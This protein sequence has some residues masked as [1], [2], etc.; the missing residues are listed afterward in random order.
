MKYL[1]SIILAMIAA[2]FPLISSLLPSSPPDSEVESEFYDDELLNICSQAKDKD[3]V[4][5]YNPGGMGSKPMGEDTQWKGVVEGIES[6]LGEMGYTC[7]IVEHIRTDATWLGYMKE[8]KDCVSLFSVKSREL[9]AKVKFLVE[10]VKDIK[11]IITGASMGAVFCSEVMGL[12]KADLRAYSIEAGMPF[13]HR[14]S[15]SARTLSIND[16]GVTPDALSSGSIRAIARS[17]F[18]APFRWLGSRL[19]GEH[20][21]L[22]GCAN[23]PGH[24]YYWD[25]PGVQSQIR[26]FLE[27]NFG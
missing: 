17:C 14:D 6:A 3:F 4:L 16:N 2:I 23:V 20:V 11:V 5:F 27:E 19:R 8:I 12:L 25:Y 22:S 18:L 9:A 21:T 7:L 13:W 26:A 1:V 24:E 10:N 15:T